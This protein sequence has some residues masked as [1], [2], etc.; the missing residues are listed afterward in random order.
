M[1]EREPLRVVTSAVVPL[2]FSDIDTDQIIPGR[3]ITSRT[4]EEFAA[5]LFAGRREA[6]PYFVLDQAGMAGRSILVA[7]RNFG[8]GSSR[9]Q[10]VWALQAGGF[11]VI[12][13]P[14][15][16]DIFRNNAL[17]NGLL[18]VALDSERCAVLAEQGASEVTVDLEDRRITL[19][20]GSELGRFELDAFH[21]D[22]LMEGRSE[23][24][25]LLALDSEI[26]T[27]EAVRG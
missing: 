4:P 26:A 1:S 16:G 8:C 25:Y 27:F 10:A 2:M 13:A 14:S 20:D 24:D 21:R 18:T 15:F 23:L 17:Q 3:Y 12:V 5:A 6:E 19:T 11:R 22:L 7:E 9:E